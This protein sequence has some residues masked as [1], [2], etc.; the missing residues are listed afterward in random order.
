MAIRTLQP[1]SVSRQGE[2]VDVLIGLRDVRFD[3]RGNA[4]L[5][6]SGLL[7]GVE[8]GLSIVLTANMRPGF[9]GERPD[10]SA[11]YPGGIVAISNGAISD[12]FVAGLSKL[13]GMP[14]PAAKMST[15]FPITCVA[16]HG[17][18]RN[19]REEAV[20]FKLFF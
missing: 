3:P 14:T 16:T 6:A 20:R 4:L 7:D 9:V 12:L 1:I 17:D 13:Y 2:L 18:P 5:A 10:P 15:Q 8:V 19:F 11:I